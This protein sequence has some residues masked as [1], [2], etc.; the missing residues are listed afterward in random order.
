[1]KAK[2]DDS[3][4][5]YLQISQSVEDDILTGAIAEEELIPSTNQFAKYYSIN[6][7]TAAKGINLLVADGIIYKKRGIGMCVNAGAR[8]AILEKRRKEFYG[9]YIIPLMR[10]AE[11]LEIS[12]ADIIKMI[13]KGEKYV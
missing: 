2:L 5:I 7:A 3:A 10:E 6:P 12:K 11:N 9:K 13:E 4:L 1:M 8:S